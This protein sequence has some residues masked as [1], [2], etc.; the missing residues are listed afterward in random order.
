MHDNWVQEGL[1]GN[2]VRDTEAIHDYSF[3]KTGMTRHLHKA[4]AW[5]SISAG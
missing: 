4:T 3:I 5:R 1:A 2:T